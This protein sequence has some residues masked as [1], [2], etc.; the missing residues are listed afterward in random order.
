[1][2]N[3][4]IRSKIVDKKQIIFKVYNINNHWKSSITYNFF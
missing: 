2:E 1:M 3:F 4:I